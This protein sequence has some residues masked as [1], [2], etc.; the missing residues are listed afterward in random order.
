MM[1]VKFVHPLTTAEEF[2]FLIRCKR[3]CV[4]RMVR[5][6]ELKGSRR[7]VYIN[8]REVTKFGLDV[9]Q[10]LELLAAYRADPGLHLVED[11]A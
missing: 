2:G 6:G 11:A 4:S 9:D 10:A 5:N 1:H 8:V 7:P 3:A